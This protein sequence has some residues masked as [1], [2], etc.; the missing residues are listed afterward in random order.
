MPHV[1]V[2]QENNQDIQL[3]FED[4]GQGEPVVL[5]HGYP[6]NGHSWERQEAALLDAGYRVITYDRR[7]FG[8]SSQPSAGYDYDTFAADLD[9]LLRHLDL[10]GVTLAGF[11]MGGGEVA[12]YI[13]KYGESR[14]KKAVFA[15][16][17]APYLVKT[18]DNPEGV[19]KSVFDGIMDQIRKDRFAFFKGFFEN[20]YNADV[21]RGSRVSDDVLH[22][23]FMVA[24]SAS[25][26]ATLA[27]VPAWLEDFRPD[28]A[29]IT[30]PTLIVQGD[31]D[32]IVPMEASGGRLPKLIAGSEM[33]VI[34]DGPHAISWTHADELNAALLAFLRK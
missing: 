25:A 21:F 11:S 3:Y 29:K 1:T 27:C 22:Q 23:S 34:K 2:G 26:R 14:I 12:R 32:R 18:S 33:V 31:Q 4:H 16:P 17:V 24:A 8:A 15:S 9:A 20:F 7:G 10:T 19:D 13:G 5:I 30:V 6:L 28:V